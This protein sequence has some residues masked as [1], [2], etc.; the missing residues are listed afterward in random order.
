MSLITIVIKDRF[1]RMKQVSLDN[2]LTENDLTKLKDYDSKNCKMFKIE[3]SIYFSNCKI[4]QKKLYKACGFKSMDELYDAQHKAIRKDSSKIEMNG[5][6]TSSNQI[7][8]KNI[9]EK[10]SKYS[11]ERITFIIDFSA[12]NY[13]DTNGVKM[14]VDSIDNLNKAHI[15]VCICSPQGKIFVKKLLL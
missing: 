8:L 5:T 7:L 11:E 14:L 2:Q 10:K 6:A 1:L 13:I 3:S 15:F 9:T 4:I 12:V